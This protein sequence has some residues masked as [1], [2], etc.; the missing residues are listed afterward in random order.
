MRK[1]S[2]TEVPSTIPASRCFRRQAAARERNDDRIVTRQQS[3]DPNDFS[4][5]DPE[6]RLHVHAKTAQNIEHPQ[7]LVFVAMVGVLCLQY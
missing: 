6:L 4:D 3:V 7:L 5:R 1:A 2:A